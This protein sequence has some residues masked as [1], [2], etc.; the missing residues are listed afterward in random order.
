LLVQTRDSQPNWDVQTSFAKCKTGRLPS[1]FVWTSGSMAA[2]FGRYPHCPNQVST[3]Y[4]PWADSFCTAHRKKLFE[5]GQICSSWNPTSH[6]RPAW[7]PTTL[8][9]VCRC[10]FNCPLCSIFGVCAILVCVELC[11][12]KGARWLDVMAQGLTSAW[13]GGG[14]V[15]F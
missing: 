15:L 4:A 13:Y 14:C 3:V 9:G 6:L 5:V 10:I 2:G 1:A 11:M 7:H 12:H 8:G